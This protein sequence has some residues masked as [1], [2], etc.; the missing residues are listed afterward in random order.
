MLGSV[1]VRGCFRGVVTFSMDWLKYCRFTGTPSF[2]G[3][4]HGFLQI[5]QYFPLNQSTEFWDTFR[6]PF[7]KGRAGSLQT[8]K[9][10][11][12]DPPLGCFDGSIYEL[13][14]ADV[15]CQMSDAM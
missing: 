8:A 13:G 11:E 3:K 14:S 9:V 15:G 5:F 1:N 7:V 12:V 2:H 6:K 4:R 10:A